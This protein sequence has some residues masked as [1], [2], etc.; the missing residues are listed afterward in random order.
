MSDHQLLKSIHAAFVFCFGISIGSFLNACIYRMPREL[1][2]VNVRSACPAC[3]HVLRPF[4]LIPLISF[5]WLNGKCRDCGARISIR[6]F[7]IECFTGGAFVYLYLTYGFPNF[8]VYAAFLAVL[9]L[10][11]F[12]DIDTLYI[13][14]I[15]LLAGILPLIFLPLI[16]KM[17]Y[18]EVLF[19]AIAGAGVMYAIT[20]IGNVIARRTTVGFGDTLLMFLLGGFCGLNP[21]L[22]LAVIMAVSLGFL[23]ALFIIVLWDIPYF[24]LRARVLRFKKTVKETGVYFS[25]FSQNDNRLIIKLGFIYYYSIRF[26]RRRFVIKNLRHVMPFSPFLIL[27]TVLSFLFSERLIGWYSKISGY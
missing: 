27:G 14:H 10:V 25:R 3:E 22:P 20:L 11:F 26:L 7:F 2:I 12:I 19:G 18:R 8:L 15:T 1:P 13:H 6:Y 5:L 23:Y 17:N 4:D 24:R 21:R 9:T 16:S